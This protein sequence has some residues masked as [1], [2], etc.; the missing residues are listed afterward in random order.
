MFR[1]CIF[2][3]K[4]T[5]L[6]F[7]LFFLSITVCAQE[8]SVTRFFYADKD[9]TAQKEKTA[10]LDQNGDRCALIRVQT[11]MKGFVFD[12]G[13]A[14]I[15]K[16]EDDKTGEIWLWVPFGIKHI[17]IRHQQLGS[18]SNYDFPI[19]IRKAKTYVMEIT[20]NK[21]FVNNYDDT[22]KQKLHIQIVPTNNVKLKN[23]KLTINGMVVKLD[24][25]GNA[26]QELSFG[27]YTYKIEADNYF[28]QEGQF[29]INDEKKA[30]NLSIKNMA[31]RLGKLCVHV[32]LY[33]PKV[34][35]DGRLWDGTNLVPKELSIGSHE[36]K[37]SH[38][39]YQTEYR[40]INIEE[41][42]TLDI[43]FSLV[44]ET[45]YAINST[46]EGVDYNIY[47]I[48]THKV[49]YGTTNRYNEHKLTTGKYRIT[50]QKRGYREYDKIVELDSSNPFID[51]KLYPI[52]ND[53]YE[54]YIEG[55]YRLGNSTSVGGTMG[56]YWNNVNFD[57]SYQGGTGNEEFLY[58]SEEGEKPYKFSYSISSIFTTKI[59]YGIP[60]GRR[61]R[62]TPQ[63]GIQHISITEKEL[64]DDVNG[65]S[66][67]VV[68][69]NCQSLIV[70]SRISIALS[71][72]WGMSIS[73]EY[74]VPIKQSKGFK[75]LSDASTKIKGWGEGFNVNLGLVLYY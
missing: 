25:N 24:E 60:I 37:V 48:E 9:L 68:D 42:K 30:Q 36:V 47:N 56:F 4:H 59:G 34:E 54:F 19:A 57:I 66:S 74:L 26:T 39:G 14:G 32:N 70:S 31:L 5:Y 27:T 17:S 41:N 52:M 23:P 1:D 51:I 64:N 73:P 69:S 3:N 21:V 28:P 38:K 75:H 33:N 20:S 72:H 45:V 2:L 11:T 43:A 13:S 12:V 67:V 50:A 7:F 55:N 62:I 29:L 44:R 6:F 8:I 53:P 18:L 22:H 58:W 49:V 71:K 61:L 65:L 16:I 46:P 15:T 10:V 40:T 35:V 63:L